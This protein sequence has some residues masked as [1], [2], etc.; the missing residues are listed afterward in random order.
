MGEVENE[1]L[2]K[3]LC[4]G[5]SYRVSRYKLLALDLYS[6]QLD[7]KIAEGSDLFF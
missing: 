5:R 6:P 3:G 7:S 4:L 1:R 2:R